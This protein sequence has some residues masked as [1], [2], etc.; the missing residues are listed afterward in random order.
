[1]RTRARIMRPY[2]VNVFTL[3]PAGV[4]MANLTTRTCPLCSFEVLSISSCLSHLR[5]F[6]SSDPRFCVTCGIGGCATTCRS[7]SSLYS[8][9][10]RRHKEDG[11]IQKRKLK[12]NNVQDVN[13]CV[14]DTNNDYDHSEQP[15]GMTD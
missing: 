6:H 10:Y 2:A 13:H 9:V 11:I 4:K 15:Q 7:F 12:E 3:C 8:H 14:E 5:L 1:M